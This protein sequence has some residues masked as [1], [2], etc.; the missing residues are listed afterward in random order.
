M[1]DVDLRLR[2]GE[3][4]GLRRRR[5]DLLRGTV[6]VAKIV[7]EVRG[8]PHMGPPRTR[9]GRRT[10]TLPRSVVEEMGAPPGTRTPNRCLKSA[11]QAG[12]GPATQAREWLSTRYFPNQDCPLLTHAGRCSVPPMCPTGPSGRGR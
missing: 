10:V 5:L 8:E 1:A 3:L 7:V 2:I 6:D 9:A 4:A 11:K 12:S